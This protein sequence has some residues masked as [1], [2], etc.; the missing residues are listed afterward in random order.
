MREITFLQAINEAIDEEMKR[1]PKVFILGE[2]I[3]KHW[4]GAMGDLKGLFDKYGAERVLDTPIS[5]TAIQGGAIGAAA[6]D[7]T[8]R[9]YVLR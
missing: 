9:L 7:E 6:T 1:D 2:D 4:G 8:N 3:G 5:E